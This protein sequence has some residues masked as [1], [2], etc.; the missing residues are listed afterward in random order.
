MS[1]VTLFHGEKMKNQQH[2]FPR[3]HIVTGTSFL[4]FIT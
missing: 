2:D 1:R 4:F 3:Y